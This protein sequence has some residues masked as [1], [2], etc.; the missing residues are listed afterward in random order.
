MRGQNF[1]S[2]PVTKIEASDSIGNDPN[3]THRMT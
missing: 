3:I 1:I 2:N